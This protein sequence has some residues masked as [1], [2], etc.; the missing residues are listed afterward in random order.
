MRAA[1][2]VA[3]LVSA[4]AFAGPETALREFSSSQIKKGVRA[5]GM[6]G[7]GATIGNYSLVYRDAGGALADY[8]ITHFSDTGNDIHFVAAGFTTP[9]FWGDSAFYIVAMSSWGSDMRMHLRSPGFA[10]GADF[11][12]EGSDEAVFAKFAKKLPKGF[13]VGGLFG[14]ERSALSAVADSGMGNLTYSTVWLPSGGLGASWENEHILTGVR[15]LLSNDWE[16]R[17]DPT[18][19]QSGWLRSYEFR[20]GLAIKPWRGTIVDA[21]WVGLL[22]GSDVD[23]TSTYVNAFILGIEQEVW[24]RHLWL[25]GGWNETAP[26]IGLSARIEPF[27]LDVAW[28]HNLGVDRSNGVFG[29]TDDAV[30]ATLNFEYLREHR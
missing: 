29:K 8:G 5:L 12:A 4:T 16:T 20:V 28:V 18:G 7:N 23:R 24:R 25:R 27:K 14:W 13:A 1:A 22:R 3:F 17:R 9:R 21:G 11:R 2:V 19:T 30:L 6:G 10:S 15:A 26:T